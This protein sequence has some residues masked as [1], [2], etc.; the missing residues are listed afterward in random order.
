[1]RKKENEV[2]EEYTVV[3]EDEVE[4]DLL[5]I[6]RVLLNKIWMIILCVIVG[7]TLAFGVTKFVITP[8]YTATSMIYILSNTTSISSA[9]DLQ[10]SKQLTID[11][12]ILAKSR[13]VIE[14]VIGSL[15]LDYEYEEMLAL[16]EVEN[17]ESSSILR[18]IVTTPNPQLSKEIANELADVTADRVAEVMV[19][20]KPSKVESAITPPEPS[21]PSTL[22]NTALGGLGLGFIMALIIVIKHLLDDTIKNDE[23]V[24][25]YLG[26]S[27]L[28][29][30][31]LEKKKGIK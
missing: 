10:L 31:P 28:A 9:V 5:E 12:E 27:T 25:K 14:R 16:L 13:P 22:K 1:M 26:L 2:R 24:K 8:Q 3:N 11:F 29:E 21:S 30:I 19:T 4:I 7:V 18:I 15:D 6:A 23:D 20:D 17:P